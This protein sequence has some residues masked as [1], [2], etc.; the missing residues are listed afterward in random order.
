MPGCDERH[1]RAAEAGVV[2]GLD[3]HA[4]AEDPVGRGVRDAATGGAHDVGEQPHGRRLAVRAGDRD[5]RDVG[6]VTVGAGPG[7]TAAIRCG[8]V[9]GEA[10]ERAAGGEQ[11]AH[12]GGDLTGERLGRVASPPREREHDLVVAGPG[13]PAHAETYRRA[14]WASARVTWA[15]TRAVNRRRCSL[16]GRR[17]EARPGSA[18]L[19]RRCARAGRSVARIQPGTASV[20]F[21]AGRGKYRFGPSSTRSSTISTRSAMAGPA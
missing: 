1:L 10:R 12:H 3:Q 7:S 15:P 19:G 2:A 4:V 8:R 6:S 16:P 5:D 21:T 18:D 9:G 14:P 11:I 17:A 20:S 13:A